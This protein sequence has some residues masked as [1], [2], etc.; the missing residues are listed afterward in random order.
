MASILV[1]CT[2]TVCRSPVAEGFLCSAVRRRFAERA[3]TVES[4][5]TFGWE[6]SPASPES[7]A[8][9]LELGIDIAGHR[10]RRLEAEHLEGTGLVL[11]MA[12]EHRT[13]VVRLAPE[14]AARTF[15]LKELVRLLEA[16][17]VASGDADPVAA[18]AV[19]AA[20]ADALRRNGFEGDP[21]DEDIADPLGL[22]IETYRAVAV[23]LEEWCGRL[24]DG[25]FGRAHARASA[26]GE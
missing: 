12:S 19:R 4:V 14:T 8:A 21:E 5:G 9:A 7:V 18:L 22:P 26:E 6:G 2:G 15:T 3:P 10:A 11:A 23:E 13:A 20:E 25:L 17:P 16:L 1:V 24:T